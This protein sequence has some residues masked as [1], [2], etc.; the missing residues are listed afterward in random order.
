M[1]LG[2]KFGVRISIVG[3]GQG[4]WLRI[5]SGSHYWP[6]NSRQQL[7][8]VVGQFVANPDRVG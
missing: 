2:G 4:R 3:N 6:F 1:S 5:K 7:A 8:Q